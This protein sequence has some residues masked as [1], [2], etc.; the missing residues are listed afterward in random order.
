M[1][2][3]EWST[4]GATLFLE[5]CSH[6]HDF[7]GAPP[8]TVLARNSPEQVIEAIHTGMMAPIAMFMTDRQM[9]AVADFVAGR[10]PSPD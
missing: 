5:R 4:L 7:G 3:G 6:C 8:R 9:L 2:A 10:R 1:P